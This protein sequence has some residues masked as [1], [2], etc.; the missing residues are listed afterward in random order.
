M[1][2]LVLMLLLAGAAKPETE[3]TIRPKFGF[4]PLQ[5]TVTARIKNADAEFYCPEVTVE[6]S[7]GTKS[8]H[9]EDCEPFEK[10]DLGDRDFAWSKSKVLEQGRHSI[11]VTLRQNKKS[12]T[13]TVEIEVY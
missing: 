6:W 4:S 8:T 9:Q 10:L 5:A 11:A 3:V 2:H 13:K 7:D 12:V 1:L